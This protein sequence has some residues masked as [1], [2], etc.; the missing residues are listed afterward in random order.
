MVMNGVPLAD[1]SSTVLETIGLA[2]DEIQ[3]GSDPVET[4]TTRVPWMIDQIKVDV[5]DRRF[6][7]WGSSTA[8]DETLQAPVIPRPLFEHLHALAGVT[9]QWP[10]GNAGLLHVYGYLLSA[11]DTRYGPKRRRWLGPQLAVALGLDPDHFVPRPDVEGSALQRVM[12]IAT[13]IL[14]APRDRDDLWFWADEYADSSRSD[15]SSRSRS[16][17]SRSSR[18]RSSR[19]SSSSNS[20]GGN[21]GASAASGASGAN[22]NSGDLGDRGCPVMRTV[23]V[24]PAGCADGVLVYGDVGGARMRLV[25]M[26]PITTV[27]PGWVEGFVASTPRLRYNAT[28]GGIAEAPLDGRKVFRRP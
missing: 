2:G 19:S 8:F 7:S 20:D 21:S 13:P 24:Q 11:V 5:A 14:T 12:A 15:S 16:S 18:S 3:S 9:A 6:A 1:Q 27:A 28:V 26:F 22:R 17:R 23:V 4:L 10:I 25:T